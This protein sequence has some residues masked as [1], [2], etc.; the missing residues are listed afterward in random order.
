MQDQHPVSWLLNNMDVNLCQ[1]IHQ[2]V[3]EIL[4]GEPLQPSNVKMPDWVPKSCFLIQLLTRTPTHV[5][6]KY[7]GLPFLPGRGRAFSLQGASLGLHHEG[8]LRWPANSGGLDGA[9]FVHLGGGIR[10]MEGVGRNETCGCQSTGAAL[11]VWLPWSHQRYWEGQHSLVYCVVFLHE[12]QSPLGIWWRAS[13]IPKVTWPQNSFGMNILGMAPEICKWFLIYLGGIDGSPL[14]RLDS[15]SWK[16]EPGGGR[17]VL[18]MMVP[19]NLVAFPLA[20]SQF[21]GYL[22]VTLWYFNGIGK[23]TGVR[24]LSG[25]SPPDPR[26]HRLG[27][28]RVNLRTPGSPLELQVLGK[29]KG[30]ASMNPSPKSRPWLDLQ[31]LV[32]YTCFKSSS[33]VKSQNLVLGKISKPRPLYLFQTVVPVLQTFGDPYLS[34]STMFQNYCFVVIKLSPMET[35]LPMNIF[36]WENW[37]PTKCL[38]NSGGFHAPSSSSVSIC[39]KHVRATTCGEGSKTPRSKQRGRRSHCCSCA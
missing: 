19:F 30:D 8:A 3:A 36:I 26:Y 2:W 37:V 15:R 9:C 11:G 39:P 32:L 24:F 16:G 33:L 38:L 31:N 17:F 28:Q 6:I 25:T 29:T 14:R 7:F 27:G 4:E 12:A 18:F 23:R 10:T 34:S 1:T 5:L 35:M 20:P 21:F 22:L 13:G